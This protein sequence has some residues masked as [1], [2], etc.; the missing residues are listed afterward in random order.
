MERDL[1]SV[2]VGDTVELRKSHPCGGHLFEVMY[3]GMDVRLK[4]LT[5]GS[6]IR[7]LRR[8]FG[9][10]VKNIRPADQ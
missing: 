6:Q 10:M 4:C 2:A 8:K 3:V 5:C 9:K 1:S 7:L